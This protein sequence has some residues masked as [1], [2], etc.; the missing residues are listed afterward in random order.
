MN[1]YILILLFLGFTIPK[2]EAQTTSLQQNTDKKY[3]LVDNID[4]KKVATSMTDRMVMEYKLTETQAQDI[5]EINY[6]ASSRLFQLYQ[7]QNALEK[8]VSNYQTMLNEI[9]RE[10]D[11]KIKATLTEEQLKAY[12]LKQK[13]MQTAPLSQSAEKLEITPTIPHKQIVDKKSN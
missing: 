5:F 3:S 13:D 11:D 2:V 8:E 4:A 12:E 7:N 9:K 6:L 1:N 10:A